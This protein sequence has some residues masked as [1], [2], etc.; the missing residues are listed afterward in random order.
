MTVDLVREMLDQETA[1]IREPV[2]EDTWRAGR[3]RETPEI[4]ER[5]ALSEELIEFL[6]L[7]AYEHLD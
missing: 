3:P 4:F 5:V 1:R 7:I 2:G 6:T